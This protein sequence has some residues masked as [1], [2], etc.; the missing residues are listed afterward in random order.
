MFNKLS[1]PPLGSIRRQSVQGAIVVGFTEEILLYYLH[2]Q[3][4]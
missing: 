4:K 1:P 2:S 3:D